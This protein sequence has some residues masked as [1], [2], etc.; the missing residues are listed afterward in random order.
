MRQPIGI[1]ERILP[2]ETRSPITWNQGS[3]FSIEIV[4]VSLQGTVPPGPLMVAVAV[5]LP[6]PMA[7]PFIF[8]V[9]GLLV[10]GFAVTK[11]N[12]GGD[13]EK[14]T[15][16]MVPFD[17][18]LMATLSVPISPTSSVTG[19]KEMLQLGGG[20][21]GGGGG[22]VGT[23]SVQPLQLF[24]AIS[25]ADLSRQPQYRL[26]QYNTVHSETLQFPQ[27]RVGAGPQESHNCA[28]AISGERNEEN[29]VKRDQNISI[30]KVICFKCILYLKLYSYS[31]F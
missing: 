2:P 30:G 21:G 13:T 23:G 10:S 26:A 15:C 31:C 22:G 9:N 3:G 4:F 27:Q 5:T 19:L 6:V 11:L 1:L 25:Q 20:G 18:W 24:C 8:I 17:S 29:T 16:E 28:C 12:T 7:S 14:R